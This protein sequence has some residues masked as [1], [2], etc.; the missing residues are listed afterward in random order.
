MIAVASLGKFAGA[1]LGAEIGGLKRREAIAVGCGMNAR[2]STEIIVASIGLS[3]G[4]LSQTLYTMIVSM[5]VTTTMVMPPMLRWALSR[6]P[7]R[8]SEKTPARARSRPKTRS[9]SR[10]WRRLLLAVDESAN[11]RFASYI[12]GLLAGRRGNPITV[13]PIAECRN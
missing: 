5:A 2:G 1:F 3:L 11:G 10:T 7:L 4:A 12:A 13:L 6:V 8:A 9:S